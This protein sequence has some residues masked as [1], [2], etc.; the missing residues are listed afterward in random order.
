MVTVS[1]KPDC[2]QYLY[3]KRGLFHSFSMGQYPKTKKQSPFRT[4]SFF[5]LWL[6]FSRNVNRFV[7]I[8]TSVFT[9]FFLLDSYGYNQPAIVQ[10]CIGTRSGDSEAGGEVFFY[11][12]MICKKG[13]EIAA[14]SESSWGTMVCTIMCPSYPNVFQTILIILTILFFT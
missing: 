5:E 14:T 3:T 11:V 12:M 9:F 4:T 2:G 1:V 10:K 13:E 6:I 7:K 8:T